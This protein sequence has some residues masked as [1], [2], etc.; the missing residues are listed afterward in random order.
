MIRRI[1]RALARLIYDARGFEHFFNVPIKFE[2]GSVRAVNERILEQAF[3]ISQV[4]LADDP[5]RVLD[6][7]CAKS[8]LS[9]MLA[10]L[11]H[12][13][14]GVDLRPFP[15]SHPNLEF[16]RENILDLS[17][18]PFDVAVSLSTIEHVGLGAYDRDVRNDDI[19][20][21]AGRIHELL[22]P[23]GLFIVTLPV[24]KPSTDQFERSFSPDEI[25]DVMARVG[26]GMRSARYFVRRQ[27]MYWEPSSETAIRAVRND[28]EARRGPGS[29]VNG[30]GCFVFVN[31]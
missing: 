25:K 5:L 3:V 1:R 18:D 16:H 6:F 22:V 27:G 21:V 20:R 10:S 23:H 7:G 4:G 19:E 26:F 28:A 12:H 8:W 24:G 13:V 15:F 9:L 11:G 30:V 31:G 17:T 14:V 2:A 29:G